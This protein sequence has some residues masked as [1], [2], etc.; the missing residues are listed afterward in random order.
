MRRDSSDLEAWLDLR[1][2]QGRLLKLILND[3]YNFCNSFPLPVNIFDISCT[4]ESV[5][6]V[7]IIYRRGASDGFRL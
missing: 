5:K 6:G 1:H 2:W 7:A 4:R 3:M